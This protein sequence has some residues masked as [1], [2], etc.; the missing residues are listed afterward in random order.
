MEIAEVKA[1]ESRFKSSVHNSKMF[2]SMILYFVEICQS[3]RPGLKMQ[4]SVFLKRMKD[5]RKFN[6]ASYYLK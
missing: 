6:V 2:L 3:V 4:W 5:I 1:I